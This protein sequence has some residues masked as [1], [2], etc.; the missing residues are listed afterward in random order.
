MNVLPLHD[1]AADLALAGGKGASLA[2]LAR[3]GLP[4]PAGFH[5]TTDAYRDFVSRDGLHDLIMETIS[6]APPEQAARRIAALF[7]ERD[8]PPEVADRKSVV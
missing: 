3:A 5:I 4:V 8:M 1:T 2:R 7:A 6:S